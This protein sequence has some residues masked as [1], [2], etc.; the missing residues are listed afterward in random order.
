MFEHT[1]FYLILALG[2]AA[3]MGGLYQL[4]AD[5][6]AWLGTQGI[7]SSFVLFGAV[8]LALGVTFLAWAEAVRK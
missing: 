6:L 8:V 3:L 7:S 2:M 1:T 5:T 4:A